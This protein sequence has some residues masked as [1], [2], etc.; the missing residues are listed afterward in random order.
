[1]LVFFFSIFWFV[2]SGEVN[3]KV[4][5]SRP[6]GSHHSRNFFLSPIWRP[7]ISRS[8]TSKSA[9]KVKRQIFLW[10]RRECRGWG[11][12]SIRVKAP[13]ILNLVTRWSGELYTSA[14]V[15]EGNNSGTHW[16][17]GWLG[18]WRCGL[19]VLKQIKNLIIPAGI[20]NLDSQDRSCYA[21]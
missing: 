2:Y 6:N 18:P 19:D 13:L 3:K 16:I 7:I 12:G 15:H 10:P 11:G 21:H 8:A 20:R 4:E 5:D 9:L 14:T 1:M 17:R